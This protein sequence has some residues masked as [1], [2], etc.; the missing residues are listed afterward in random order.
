MSIALFRI[1]LKSSGFTA[2]QDSGSRHTSVGASIDRTFCT[3]V[4]SAHPI[5]F[6]QLPLSK[7]SRIFCIVVSQSAVNESCVKYA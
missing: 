7:N 5:R 1:R 6:L 3:I 4:Q 2:S